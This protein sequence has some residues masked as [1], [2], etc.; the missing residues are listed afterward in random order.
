VMIVFVSS[1]TFWRGG[2]SVG[3][4]YITVMLPFVLPPCAAAIAE[5]RRRP[6]VLGAACGAIVF[7]VVVYAGSAATFPYWPDSLALP[8]YDVT[9]RLWRD[10][11]VAPNIANEWGMFGLLS[12]APYLAAVV[13]LTGWAI[14]RLVG[15]RGLAIAAVVAALLVAALGL[16]PHGD[17]H[18]ER[19]YVQTMRGR[20]ERVHRLALVI[21]MGLGA[22]QNSSGAKPGDDAILL[23]TT[24]DPAEQA[25]NDDKKCAA[26]DLEACR[27]LGTEYLEGKGVSQDL[28]RSTALFQQACNG[29]IMSA[30]N[31]LANAYAEGTG[32]EKNPQRA[33]EVYQ[34]ACDGGIKPACRNLG[35]ML[36]DGRGVPAD[37]PRAELLLDKACKGSVPLA[38]TSAGDLDAMLAAKGAPNRSKQAIAHYK[39]G[40]ET[41]D[42]TACRQ[43]GVV[44]LEGKGMP[45]SP[46]TA[47][48]W[49]QRA[50]LADEAVGCRLLGAMLVQGAGVPRDVERGKQLLARACDA[51]DADACKLLELVREPPGDA[52]APEAPADAELHANDGP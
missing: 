13:G 51:K 33:A 23:D 49:L 12:V 8:L 43:L 47:E 21:A 38:C 20:N 39:H 34:R 35:L 3:P 7:A 32:I 19:A 28:P 1:L 29:A 45:K 50:C 14:V 44:Y 40:C 5:L 42:P 6:L 37:L 46:T 31:A 36:R 25:A 2:W 15:W 24:T 9:L 30:C 52:G 26:G 18:A 17:D 4:R 22:C 11:G 16:V 27:R 41:G 48:V 10:G